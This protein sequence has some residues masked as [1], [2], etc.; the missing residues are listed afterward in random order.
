MQLSV[1]TR[2]WGI[3]LVAVTGLAATCALGV[4]QIQDQ[5]KAER[6]QQVRAAV[7]E[8]TGVVDHFHAKAERGELTTAQA[9][10]Q[11]IA[12]LRGLR[13]D[14]GNYIWVND[15]QTVIVLHPTKPELE[16]K[17]Q[18]GTRDPDGVYLFREF[19][20][21]VQQRGSGFVPYQWPKPGKSEPQPKIS[22]V[23]GY[24]EWS[25]V[26]GSGT[27][28]DDIRTEVISQ[29]I[30]L[31]SV[32]GLAMALLMAWSW[33]IARRLRRDVRLVVD[34]VTA[35]A[36]G[37]LG[38]A[39]LPAGQDEL[40]EIGRAVTVARRRLAEQES[41]LAAAAAEREEQLRTRFDRQR[42]ADQ[43]VRRR[44][45]NIVDETATTVAEDLGS[46][47]DQV[48][49]VR[50]A[51]TTIDEKVA[52]ADSITREVIAQ[53]AEADQVAAALTTSLRAVAGMAHLIAGVADQTKM[54]ALNATIEAARAGEAGQG[55]SVVANEVKELATT[56]ARSTDEITRTINGLEH[57][58]AAVGAAIN[59][60]STRIAGLDVATTALADIATQQRDLVTSLDG[61][62]GATI[63]RVRDMSALTDQL[64]RRRHARVG[65]SGR[66]ILELAGTTVQAQIL[67]LGEGGLRCSTDT[68][69][70]R[71]VA[72]GAD[73]TVRFTLQDSPVT[74][75]ATIAHRQDTGASTSIGVEFLE[76]PENLRQQIRVI[77]EGHR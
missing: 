47:V 22:F 72:P 25:W 70:A 8:A 40:G 7:E 1:V 29:A 10:Q 23:S 66:A 51:A 2:V 52:S 43:P 13:F 15:L 14:H 46:M 9:Q 5:V 56:T 49:S 31:G 77:V 61:T 28:T 21:V 35:V 60:M 71:A 37:D 20:Q 24:P 6:R 63:A 73:G 53:A 50:A 33:L 3:V 48:G 67:D 59:R 45:Q 44:A 36:A 17:S 19:V 74:V 16:G 65:H 27:Y 42:E 64:E 68:A 75:P 34:A 4:A 54:L 62:V 12:V 38:E 26:I 58:A 30:R 57:D 39:E 69:E 55:F 18:D 32:M 76:V 11:A 41:E